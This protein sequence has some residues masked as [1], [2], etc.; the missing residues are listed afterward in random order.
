MFLGLTV[1]NAGN[2][3]FHLLTGRMLG[4]ANY[5]ELESIISSLYL[6]GIIPIA[7][8]LIVVKFVSS[9][10][11]SDPEEIPVFFR[12][13]NLRL[14]VFGVFSLVLLLLIIPH[15][16]GFLK[17]DNSL[18]VL[19][20]MLSFPL[21]LLMV[22]A[23][24]FLQGL[25]NFVAFTFSQIIEVLS[26]LLL[27]VLFIRWGWGVSGV[28]GAMVT[29]SIL[30]FF[31]ALYVLR[32]FFMAHRGKTF[33]KSKQLLK[34]G[35]SVVISTISLTSLFT[36]DIVL[37]KHYFTS[38]EAGIYASLSILGKIIFFGSGPFV[39]AMFPMVSQKK[40]KGESYHN[41][42]WITVFLV[43]L[44]SLAVS[45]IY[46][47]FPDLMIGLLFG[48][49]YLVGKDLLVLFAVFI[50][51]YSL[52]SV[53]VN[54]Y[55]SISKTIVVVIPLFFS[56]VQVVLIVIFH[57]SLAMVIIDSIITCVLLFI[58]LLIYYPYAKKP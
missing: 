55:L 58:S 3:L 21:S 29:A 16:A 40:E 24:S 57:Q 5:G 8:N 54:F 23:R 11:A 28:S 48:K 47:V 51:L 50:S 15:W 20:A 41:L 52:C 42:F 53:F 4:P 25:M 32:P 56:I 26:K 13:L 12:W 19:I 31:Y 43:L 6:L 36:T 10:S 22:T 27:A 18:P 14:I 35:F 2:Y 46:F 7:L 45:A 33:H 17:L 38:F 1:V 44:S 9:Q 49:E 30:G 34:Y 39:T 37:V